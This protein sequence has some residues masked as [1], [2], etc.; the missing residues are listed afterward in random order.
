MRKPPQ[1]SSEGLFNIQDAQTSKAQKELGK[2]QKICG[3]LL[4]ILVLSLILT[5]LGI[6]YFWNPPPNKIYGM[7]HTFVSQ[8]EMQK[9]LMKIDPVSRT[10]IFRTGK[11]REEVLEIHDFKNG[12]TGI[13]F[14]GDPK[15]FIRRQMKGIPE[16]S[17]VEAE[18]PESEEVT[19]YLEQS[20]VWVP[21]E[22]PVESKDFLENSKI[23]DLCK[24]VTTYWIH[25]TLLTE[26]EPLNFD[27]EGYADDGF[28]PSRP[29]EEEMKENHWAK[30]ARPSPRR[31]A[32]QLTEQDLPVNDY[33]ENGL[34][35]HPM[36]DERGYCCARCRRAH[37]YCRR[38][39][40]P[41]LGYYPYPYC[42][43]GGRVI[44]RV[45]MPCNWWIARML[46][47]V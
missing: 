45:I 9:I 31:H 16:T 13:F 46:G 15:C 7:E 3:V 17:N 33:T 8:G 43:Q 37:R 35:F 34:E 40:E 12:I 36:W 23:F 11:D 30:Q 28:P 42:Y 6:Q 27:N 26:P 14:V 19:T 5:F 1:E 20:V 10:E 44:C 4:G 22:K 18:E 2:R 21:G 29:R 38:V 39:C 41:L 25:P 47:R 32:R 24:N